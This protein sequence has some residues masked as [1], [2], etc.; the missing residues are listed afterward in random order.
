MA[1]LPTGTAGNYEEHMGE[2]CRLPGFA[3]VSI[4]YNDNTT[5]VILL[6]SNDSVIILQEWHIV[7]WLCLLSIFPLNL[8]F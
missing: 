3:I 6:F 5:I 4:S 2:L 7:F 1:Y 8:E